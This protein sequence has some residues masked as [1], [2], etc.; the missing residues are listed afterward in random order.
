[1]S[2]EI[3]GH[4]RWDPSVSKSNC[5]HIDIFRFSFI[6]SKYILPIP[7]KGLVERTEPVQVHFTIGLRDQRSMWMQDG[8]KKYSTWIPTWHQMDHVSWSPGLFSK[9]PLGGRPNTK[10]GDH[11]TPNGHNRWF[12]LFYH[13]WG[14]RVNRNSSK[15]HLVEGRSHMTSHYTRGSVT[16]L[17]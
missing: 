15:R 9:P 5:L 2:G 13:V 16:T 6:N 1:M 8:C 11:G 14:P 7:P 17:R 12:I 10:P 4:T 3:F